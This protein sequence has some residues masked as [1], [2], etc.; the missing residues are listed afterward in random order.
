MDN[1]LY[2]Y[3]IFNNKKWQN[4]MK[5]NSLIEQN[6]FFSQNII[7]IFSKNKISL[8]E[9]KIFKTKITYQETF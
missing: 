9:L 5:N 7:G 1:A 8:D 3:N 4:I 2:L 6:M